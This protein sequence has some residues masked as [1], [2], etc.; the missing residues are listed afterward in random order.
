MPTVRWTF[1]KSTNICYSLL[2]F[3]SG[4][5][6]NIGMETHVTLTLVLRH[7]CTLRT[8]MV[9]AASSSS[10]YYYC[11][12][13]VFVCSQRKFAETAVSLMYNR[14]IGLQPTR[15]HMDFELGA[16]NAASVVFPHATI[17]GCFYRLCQVSC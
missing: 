2:L 10:S 7:S 1:Y 6:F 4:G 16:R 9:S 17:A 15:I 5:L 12:C 8:I 11:S 14:N 13:F 3:V